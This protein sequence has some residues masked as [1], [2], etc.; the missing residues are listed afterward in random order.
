MENNLDY[1][2]DYAGV[3]NTNG[4]IKMLTLTVA[5]IARLESERHRISGHSKEL[6]ARLVKDREETLRRKLIVYK[7]SREA[8]KR[9]YGL[10]CSG[11]DS[12]VRH[13]VPRYFAEIIGG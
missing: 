13:L 9:D 5:E 1:I 4:A 10:D 6:I 8:Y 7:D 3:T 11:F 12:A 2:V